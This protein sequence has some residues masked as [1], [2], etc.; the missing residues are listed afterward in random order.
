MPQATVIPELNLNK[1]QEF[2]VKADV[3]FADEQIEG[4]KKGKKA[5]K[6]KKCGSNHMQG[7]PRCAMKSLIQHELEK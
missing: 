1:I 3:N 4:Q 5:K 7:M 2:E 6:G